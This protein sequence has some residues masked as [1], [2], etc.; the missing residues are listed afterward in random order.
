MF[1]SKM[2]YEGTFYKLEYDLEGQHRK[3]CESYG[4]VFLADLRED[5][6]LVFKKISETDEFKNRQRKI[7]EGWVLEILT[8][9]TQLEFEL[10]Q[11]I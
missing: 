7:S 2:N 1:S 4:A 10:K 9:E 11:R 3:I 6:L 5:F 8:S